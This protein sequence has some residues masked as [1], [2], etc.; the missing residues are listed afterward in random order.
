MG[1]LQNL[2]QNI[3]RN[4]TKELVIGIYTIDYPTPKISHILSLL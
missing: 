3:S 2:V 4:R 1:K